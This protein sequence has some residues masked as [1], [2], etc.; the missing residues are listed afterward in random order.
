MLLR[1]KAWLCLGIVEKNLKNLLTKAYKRGIMLNTSASRLFCVAHCAKERCRLLN[2]GGT[3]TSC[4]H[5]R[6]TVK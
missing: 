1:G 4:S 2:E 6:A 5:G 3:R